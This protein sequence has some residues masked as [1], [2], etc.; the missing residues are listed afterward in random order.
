MR[1]RCAW[2]VVLE[3]PTTSRLLRLAQL[4]LLGEVVVGFRELVL[5]DS[6]HSY[7][8]VRL[9][10]ALCLC[11]TESFIFLVMVAEAEA[12]TAIGDFVPRPRPR[13]GGVCSGAGGRSIGFVQ[14]CGFSPAVPLCV[15]LQVMAPA[16]VGVADLTVGT[17]RG[18]APADMLLS[19][20]RSRRL[21]RVA[22]AATTTRLGPLKIRTGDL[23]AAPVGFVFLFGG[24]MTASRAAADSFVQIS[25]RGLV[26]ICV[27]SQGLFCIVGTAVPVSGFILY[28]CFP[29][30]I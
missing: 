2:G 27:V 25:S 29:Y 18:V 11:A 9:G 26:C 13:F 1:N 4:R 16:P 6:C 20:F 3:V 23:A 10:Y 30:L 22:T 8:V 12:T 28:P 21:R 19:C 14:E 7:G 15:L 24:A 5:V 17:N